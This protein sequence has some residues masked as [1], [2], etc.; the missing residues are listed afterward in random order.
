MMHRNYTTLFQIQI[1]SLKYLLTLAIH[2]SPP[3]RLRIAT[4]RNSLPFSLLS[5]QENGRDG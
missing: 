1:I 4:V 3:W 2:F 5:R